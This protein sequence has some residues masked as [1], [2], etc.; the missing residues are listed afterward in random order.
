MASDVA[1]AIVIAFIVGVGGWSLR[2]CYKAWTTHKR[3]HRDIAKYPDMICIHKEEHEK[4]TK[5]HEEHAS[6]H[7]EIKEQLEYAK[8]VDI[9][10]LRSQI[11]QVYDKIINDENVS[12][13]WVSQFYSLCEL[14]FAGGGNGFV[15]KLKKNVDNMQ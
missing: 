1:V 7:V 11:L 2:G 14:Y 3:Q 10:Q 15:E 8:K 6:V 13:E 5:E 4:H 9:E 12:N